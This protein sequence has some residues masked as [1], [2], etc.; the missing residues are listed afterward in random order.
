MCNFISIARLDK[1]CEPANGNH[2]G[3]YWF[4]CDFCLILHQCFCKGLDS[5]KEVPQRCEQIRQRNKLKSPSFEQDCDIFFE[6]I[7][8][9]RDRS[10]AHYYYNGYA[11][12]QHFIQQIEETGQEWHKLTHQKRFRNQIEE[13]LIA[14]S[15]HPR[16]M[17]ARI[18]QFDDI[19][20]FFECC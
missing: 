2:T 5:L 12:R 8:G 20:S 18:S 17:M 19:E 13:E 1:N 11:Y 14:E 3:E 4:R 16:R 9:T 6:L 15:M 10:G 7:A